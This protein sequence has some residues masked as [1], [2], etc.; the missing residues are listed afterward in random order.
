MLIER[1]MKTAAK[2][3]STTLGIISAMLF[4]MIGCCDARLS[5]EYFYDAD[6]ELRFVEYDFI[7]SK[8]VGE[9]TPAIKHTVNQREL[10]LLGTIPIKTVFASSVESPMLAV[11]GNPFGIKL[12]AGGAVVVDFYDID[13]RCPAQECGLIKGDVILSCGGKEVYTNQSF[14]DII[15]ESKGE[16]MELIILRNSEKK[17]LRLSPLPDDGTYKA[18]A[19]IRDSCAGI[20]TVSFYDPEHSMLAGLGHPVCDST[21]GEIF[22]CGKGSIAP[23]EITGIR[24]SEN[25]DPGELQ[26]VFTNRP[27]L[28][29]ILENCESGI[30]GTVSQIPSGHKLIPLGFKQDI[31][32]GDATILCTL[33]NGGVQEFEIEIEKINLSDDGTKNM[34]IH[35]TDERL[36]DITGG[37]VQ[38]MSGSPIIQDGKLV[39]AVTHVFVKDTS[40][41]YGIFAENMYST[42]LSAAEENQSAAMKD[43]S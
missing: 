26:G 2:S 11:G 38:G 30:F 37:I 29:M 14:A 17:S 34:V 4:I 3:L 8:A 19:Q 5:D 16:P 28:G 1:K 22:P 21:T 42:L 7:T 6:K 25:G 41:G 40:R 24:K 27:S 32:C 20:G 9:D 33:G 18:G 35:V 12:E 23:V 15:M 13:G 36:S 31:T 10:M 43:A 39:G